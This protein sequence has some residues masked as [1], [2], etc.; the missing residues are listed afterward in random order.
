MTTATMVEQ[1]N[2]FA[3]AGDYAPGD[4]GQLYRII[5]VGSRIETGAP[6]EGNRIEG[7]GVELADWAD[8]AEGDE[9][10]VRL[11]VS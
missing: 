10:L 1:G 6:G 8:C 5:S 9:A 4:D 11:A 2:G 3:D 7:C